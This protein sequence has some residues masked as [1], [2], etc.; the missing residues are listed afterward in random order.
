MPQPPTPTPAKIREEIATIGDQI[1]AMQSND[2]A[3]QAD[4]L[5]RA[6][7]QLRKRREVLEA[8][9]RADPG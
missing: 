9:L 7:D 5:E 2:D 6:I 8:L 4:G 3:D 1:R